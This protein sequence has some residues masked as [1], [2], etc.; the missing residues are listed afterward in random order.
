MSKGKAQELKPM[1]LFLAVTV[2][3][4]CSVFFG[5]PLLAASGPIFEQPQQAT[6]GPPQLRPTAPGSSVLQGPEMPIES[7]PTT[8]ILKAE[9]TVRLTLKDAFEQA[10]EHNP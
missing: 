2:L 4:S 5:R 7:S 6:T 3:Q 9:R 10:E 1:V 8:Y